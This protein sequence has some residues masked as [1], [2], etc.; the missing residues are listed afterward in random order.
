MDVDVDA[1][2]PCPLV[3]R[4]AALLESAADDPSLAVDLHTARLALLQAFV[5]FRQ[6][7]Y[8]LFILSSHELFFSLSP[9]LR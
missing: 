3:A 5:L 7:F 2:A 4:V 1:D 9:F 6:E 8:F